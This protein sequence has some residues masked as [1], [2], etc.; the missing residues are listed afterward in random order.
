MTDGMNAAQD[1]LNKCTGGEEHKPYTLALPIGYRTMCEQCGEASNVRG[2][3]GES[4]AEY[5]DKV[6]PEGAPLMLTSRSV[7]KGQ[8][9][10]VW[11]H[12]NV[13]P[14]AHQGCTGTVRQLTSLHGPMAK[15]MAGVEMDQY[16]GAPLTWVYVH[17]LIATGEPDRDP[18]PEYASPVEMTALDKGIAETLAEIIDQEGNISIDD[19]MDRGER[20]KVEGVFTTPGNNGFAIFYRDRSGR[21]RAAHM[22]VSRDKEVFS[23]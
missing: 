18:E 12:P 23:D 8:R 20:L 10:E 17:E 22:K 19:G 7:Y 5:I 4:V 13:Q 3:A 11:Q 14:A 9:I 1:L 6:Q 2:S 21:P 16:S 15:P